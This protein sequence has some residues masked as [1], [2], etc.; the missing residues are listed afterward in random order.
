MRLRLR[1]VILLSLLAL[2]LM[3]LGVHMAFH[4]PEVFALLQSSA[5]RSSQEHV[6]AHAQDVAQHLRRR[7][8][9]V[10]MLATLPGPRELL[11]AEPPPG[12]RP[13][14]P[15]QAAVRLAGVVQRW[16][17][18]ADDVTEV[19]VIG[20]DGAWRWRLARSSGAQPFERAD[21]QG[22]RP[23]GALVEALAAGRPGGWVGGRGRASPP[24]LFVAV[25]VTAGTGATLGLVGVALDPER[26]PGIGGG[27]RWVWPD[28][29]Y[30]LNAGDP[31]VA[32]DYPELS[33]RLAAAEPFS[34]RAAGR[35]ETSW[36]PVV[37]RQGEPPVLWGAQAVDMAPLKSFVSSLK[38]TSL[39]TTLVLLAAVVVIAVA[40]ARR[41]ERVRGRLVEGV[42][43]LLEG[44]PT[45][46]GFEWG[47]PLE[48]QQLG[49]EL[50]KVAERY[51]E[52]LQSK[53]QAEVALIDEKERAEVTLASIADA[54]L[55]TNTDG[56]VEFANP[57][58]VQLLGV[59]RCEVVG[60]HVGEVVR[61]VEARTKL[62]L[63]RSAEALGAEGSAALGHVQ[64]EI[65]RRGGDTVPVEYSAA[66]IRDRTG[67]VTG[68]VVVL[69]DVSQRAELERQLSHQANHDSLTG[70]LNRR[71]FDQRL[72]EAIH[73]ARTHGACHGLLYIDLDQFKVVNDT[74]GH[75]AGDELLKQLARLMQSQVRAG[76]SLA[77]LG[78]DEFGVL[79]EHCPH[80]KA[81][82]IAETLLGLVRGH[83]FRWEGGLF[84]VG[85]SIGV[86]ILDFASPGPAEVL[87]AADMA[88]YAAK[89]SGRGRIHLSRE[90]D[91]DLEQRRT[92]MQLVGQIKRAL[93]EDRFELYCQ[94]IVPLRNAGKVP[95][96]Y[97]VLLRMRGEDGELI[98][99]GAFIP[100]AE[101]YNVMPSLDRWVVE[102]VFTWLEQWLHRLDLH[103][104]TVFNVNLSGG[105]LS[106][107]QFLEFV[108]G[109]AGR[110]GALCRQVC[111][112]I[113]ETAA[114][115]QL[116]AA[117]E[118]IHT[119]G[120][121]GFRF[122]LD[123]F[124]TGLSSFGYLKHLR[125]HSLKIDGLFVRDMHRDTADYAL[126]RAMNEVG[127]AMGIET[128][129]EYV[130][131]EEVAEMLRSMG[132]D[133]GQG[134]G[135][136]VPVPLSELEALVV[137]RTAALA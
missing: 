124:G 70:L 115:A 73:G 108:S 2:G 18:D 61:L 127:H 74:C 128:V 83:R 46:A 105:S 51:R 101:R 130:E 131:T 86:V 100:A 95:A 57:Q 79:L 35:A 125:V 55:A 24:R 31:Q 40:T 39:L 3:P 54:V 88:C 43:R 122:A 117:A 121:A 50:N 98:A 94:R 126:V 60:R 34:A 92:E 113:T 81:M 69:R 123:D 53:R 136:A 37:L 89:E 32:E 56:M 91:R 72:A 9:T 71:A 6:V 25:P 1:T 133:Y 64:L 114:I 97:E 44:S 90:S 13:L 84:T 15:E 49:Q 47:G 30:L 103:P 119:L 10:Q 5:A 45:A 110:L 42:R 87:S 59:D 26:L 7:L 11:G 82:A 17:G 65:L 66:P 107:P 28:G 134:Y 109:R 52:A 8:E 80:D 48:L 16:L 96:H 120:A 4:A 112:E 12:A 93:E 29:R 58:A 102:R 14:T 27:I 38:V 19:S 118:L 68:S 135:L 129:A 99:P 63:R 21:G 116:G 75:L 104:E 76:D 41:V 78:G 20:P 22:D 23:D 106:D 33:A 85:A 132:V 62:P 77:R 67:R 36:A 137:G 111:F